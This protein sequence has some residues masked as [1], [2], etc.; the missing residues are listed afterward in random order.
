MQTAVCEAC[1][2]DLCYLSL[3]C[4]DEMV[5]PPCAPPPLPPS[6]AGEVLPPLK[7]TFSD[8]FGNPVALPASQPLPR[9]CITACAAPVSGEALAAVPCEELVV[10]AEQVAAE[11]GLLIS[12]LQL[13]GSDAAA[14]VPGGMRLLQ[15]AGGEGASHPSAR[16]AQGAQAPPSK[17]ALPTAEIQLLISLA[18]DGSGG[19]GGLEPVVLPLRVRAGAPQ[20]LQLQPGH[21]WAEGAAVS[22]QHGTALPSFQVAAF[23]AWGNPTA[24]APDLG[25]AVLAEC[26]AL[27]PAAAEFPVTPL[28]LASVEGMGP[29]GASAASCCLHTWLGCAGRQE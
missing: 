29:L 26:E 15:A 24:P 6:S 20:S 13:L 12:G 9:L 3:V 18:G 17:Q 11:G 23:D 4:W 8:R 28:G 1:D 25:C 21:P 14:A 10:V 22:L 27:G 2:G 16:L 5:I 19:G 7:V